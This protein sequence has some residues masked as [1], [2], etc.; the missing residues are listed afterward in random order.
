[1]NDSMHS[2]MH[3]MLAQTPY[4]KGGRGWGGRGRKMHH[5]IRENASSHKQYDR[6]STQPLTQT[7]VDITL[8]TYVTSPHL[9][10][11]CGPVWDI[12]RRPA[13]SRRL[14]SGRVSP[15]VPT[16]CPSA[17]RLHQIS[18]PGVTRP[19]SLPLSL[20]IP[21]ERLSCDV[22]CRFAKGVANPSPPSHPQSP[23]RTPMMYVRKP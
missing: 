2:M 11:A 23:I 12:G 10:S 21:S 5:H 19:P 20:G 14:G 3:S 13:L 4:Q 1:M 8:G 9:T 6:T 7:P 15:T 17:W 18:A 16:F 22:G